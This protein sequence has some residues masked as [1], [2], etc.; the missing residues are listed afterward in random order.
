MT[1]PDRPAND[2]AADYDRVASAYA[3]HIHGELAGKPFDRELLDRFA[4]H[5]DNGRVCDA[6]CG[7]GHVTR[8]LHDRGC[9]AFGLDLSPAMVE[10]A[11]SFNP[12]VEF[13]VG[14]LR[15]IPVADASLAGIVCFYS[16]IHLAS[17]ELAPALAALRSKLRP[18]GQLL[19]AVH[20]GRQSIEPGELWGIPV[21]LRF[22]FLTHEQLQ[23]ALHESGLAIDQITRR[24]PYPE[25]EVETNRLYATATAP[26]TQTR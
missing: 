23:Q 13:V 25:V 1:L 17:D 19:L 18:G 26:T 7:P 15:Q 9:N 4:H 20:E 22:N 8:Y 6:G 16:L 21:A 2:V 5:V 14:D 11:R 12:G 24:A 3:K 10:H